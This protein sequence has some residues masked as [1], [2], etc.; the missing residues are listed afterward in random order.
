M[1]GQADFLKSILFA[2][3]AN[4]AIAVAKGF[5]ALLTGSELN[6]IAA[7]NSVERDFR[8]RFPI[9]TWLFLEPDVQD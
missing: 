2:L 4:S 8:S 1:A 5:A 3:F 9:T 6:M 7:I